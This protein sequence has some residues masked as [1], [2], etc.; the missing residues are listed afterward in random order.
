MIGLNAKDDIECDKYLKQ[1]ALKK[2]SF[3]EDNSQ[4]AELDRKIE[5]K[6]ALR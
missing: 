6:K 1:R 3:G 4:T 5:L 2:Q